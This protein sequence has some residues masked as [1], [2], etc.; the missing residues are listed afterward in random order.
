MAKRKTI[1]VNPLDTLVPGPTTRRTGVP[2]P[3]A[4]KAQ[5]AD[6]AAG[7]TRTTTARKQP[8]AKASPLPTLATEVT[9]PPSPADLFSRI[10]SLEKENEYI[11]WLV[12]GAILLAIML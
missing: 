9:Q 10:Q 2:S 8:T 1:L 6:P 7:S 4:A 5:S 11:K 3:A 12:G